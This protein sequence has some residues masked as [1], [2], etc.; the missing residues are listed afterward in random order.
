MLTVDN[1]RMQAF[2]REKTSIPYFSNLVWYM[3]NHV[4]E[5]DSCVRHDIEWVYLLIS[6]NLGIMLYCFPGL[7]FSFYPH[8]FLIHG[9]LGGGGVLRLGFWFRYLRLGF[10]V[11]VIGTRRNFSIAYGTKEW[12]LL[13][14]TNNDDVH[15][16]NLFYG[17]VSCCMNW[18]ITIRLYMYI[19]VYSAHM[20]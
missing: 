14:G 9:G 19:Y 3:G 11:W 4:L 7:F 18:C 20:V 5:L 12:L 10:H 15:S 13:D 6:T 8:F 16:S 17:L 1:P 2:I